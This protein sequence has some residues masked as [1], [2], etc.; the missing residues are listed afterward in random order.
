MRLTLTVTL[1]VQCQGFHALRKGEVITQAD[2]I[3][4]RKTIPRPCSGGLGDDKGCQYVT[5]YF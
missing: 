5:A 4:D 2:S 3:Q 1:L